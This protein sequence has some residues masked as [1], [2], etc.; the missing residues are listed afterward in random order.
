MAVNNNK[1]KPTLQ[2]N[3]NKSSETK[4][5]PQKSKTVADITQELDVLRAL[6]AQACRY[7][8]SGAQFR[9]LITT[10]W[11]QTKVMLG[12]NDT[13]TESAVHTAKGCSHQCLK[14]KYGAE[15]ATDI[16]SF[17]ETILFWL[18]RCTIGVNNSN[19]FHVAAGCYRF[20]GDDIIQRQDVYN[21]NMKRTCT[22]VY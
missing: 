13:T 4:T 5:Q 16:T 10:I 11:K 20:D 1:N 3:V 18:T 15:I 12:F 6:L 19:R 21:D 2:V 8:A 7:N 17:Y 9:T 14:H 22:E